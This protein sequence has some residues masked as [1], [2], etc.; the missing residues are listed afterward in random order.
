MC[1]RLILPLL[2]TVVFL[3]LV[4]VPP[5]QAKS[6]DL[7]GSW[8]PADPAM[9]LSM[10]QGYIAGAGKSNVR[11]RLIGVVAPHAGL[12]YSGEIAGYA[13][14]AVEKARP[15]LVVLVGFSHKRYLPGKISVF[16]GE[17]F[18]TPLGDVMIDEPS[19][20]ALLEADPRMSDI[21]D[22]FDDEN[23]IE[24]QIPFIQTAAPGA[25]VVL[26][27]MT[28][29]SEA[30]AGALADV[31]C[32]VFK[33]RKD[34]VIIASSD[35]CH[36]RPYAKA[37]EIDAKTI[38]S[39]Q[40]LDP[41][42]FY[43]A[44]LSAD[45]ELMCGY[46][47]V[48]AVMDASKKLGADK[49][50]VLRYAN[51]GDTSGMKDKVVG[52]LSAAFIDSRAQART[53]A[54][55]VSEQDAAGRGEEKRGDEMLTRKEKM[56]LLKIA[57]DTI[58]TYL[59]SG[60]RLDPAPETGVLK[61]NMAAFVTLHKNGDLRGCIGH[62]AATKPLYLNVRDMAIAAA[63]EDPRFR[64]VTRSEMDDIDIEI[65]ALSPMK[66]VSS[67]DDI[68]IP[69]H[70]VMVRRG[71]RSGVY[72]PQVATETGWSK[73]EFMNSLCGQKAGIPM[74][75]WRTGDCEMYVYTAEVFGEKELGI[76]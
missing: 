44:S 37:K 24:L 7:A 23:S 49:V 16:R 76:K 46:G 71:M 34:I 20:R 33:G 12:R 59:D 14:R 48:Y 9:L 60:K 18:R 61:K 26:L 58:N 64:K 53:S 56:R 21:P 47:A 43:R 50:E 72:L 75:S 74:N 55:G 51:S 36:Y 62:M 57:R 45:H 41:D 73:D 10:I 5:A 3:A 66:R 52:Y 69:G 2:T 42:V 28:D 8:Y 40:T 1:T 68:D 17:R 29:Q 31:L 54:E 67:A 22:I 35:M 38:T 63:T 11:G 39:I 25:K 15:E 19:T 6:A 65:S 13:Y 30:N 27:A 70:G 4:H 32:R